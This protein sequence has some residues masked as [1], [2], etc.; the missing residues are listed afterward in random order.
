MGQVVAL[1]YFKH[2]PDKN[3]TL[4]TTTKG[5][6]PVHILESEGSRIENESETVHS[7]YYH[8]NP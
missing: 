7:G 2:K 8:D 1:N 6:Y 4:M 3:F 5:T